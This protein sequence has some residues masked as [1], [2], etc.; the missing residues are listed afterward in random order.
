MAF[1]RGS[2]GTKTGLVCDW[3]SVHLRGL[4]PENPAEIL[5]AGIC[6][7]RLEGPPSIGDNGAEAEIGS[8]KQPG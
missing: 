8:A 5:I 3:G 2:L 4:S 6:T 7:G 1:E